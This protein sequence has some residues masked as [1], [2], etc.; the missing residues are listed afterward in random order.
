[1]QVNGVLPWINC[2]DPLVEFPG[3]ISCARDVAF[4]SSHTIK[5]SQVNSRASALSGGG[6]RHMYSYRAVGQDT[7]DPLSWYDAGGVNWGMLSP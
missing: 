4:H 7:G 1:M 5:S 6:A 3:R 2:S